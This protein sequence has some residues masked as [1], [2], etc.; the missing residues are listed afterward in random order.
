MSRGQMSFR[1]VSTLSA[2]WQ[3]LEA[4]VQGADHGGLLMDGLLQIGLTHTHQGHERLGQLLAKQQV[5]A[6]VR[7]AVQTG[8][9][10]QDGE[11][12]SW[13]QR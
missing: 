10:H 3:T 12:C 6:R 11:G 5:D 8:Q 2:V 4:D 1:G 7:T 9:Q 13:K